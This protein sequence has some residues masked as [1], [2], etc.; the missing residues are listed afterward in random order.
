MTNPISINIGSGKALD[1][2]EGMLEQD[3]IKPED[4]S[5][6]LEAL[7]ELAAQMFDKGDI[8]AIN[9]G[10]RTEL[11]CQLRKGSRRISLQ[12]DEDEEVVE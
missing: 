8:K 10:E 9:R 11:V 5:S 1:I 12:H 3:G 6:I 7:L 4:A 2:Y